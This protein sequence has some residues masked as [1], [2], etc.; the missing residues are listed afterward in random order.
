MGNLASGLS[1]KSYGPQWHTPPP[2]PKGAEWVCSRVFRI[3]TDISKS[4]RLGPDWITQFAFQKNV[5]KAYFWSDLNTLAP[6]PAK[7]SRNLIIKPKDNVGQLSS[8]FIVWTFYKVT[9]VILLLSLS[10]GLLMS[11]R[12]LFLDESTRRHQLLFEEY[13]KT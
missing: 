3:C 10:K 13:F 2:T 8:T 9:F 1:I 6:E 12:C 4:F 11:F 5:Q 7:R